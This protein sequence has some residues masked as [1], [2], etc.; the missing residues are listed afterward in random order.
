MTAKTQ[1]SHMIPSLVAA[2]M[3]ILA[4]AP[5]PYGYYQLLRLVTCG[6]AVYVAFVA[7]SWQKIWAV[8]IF[9]FVTLL[10]NPLIPIHLARE[11]WQP[12]DVT[13]AILFVIM[14]FVLKK[15]EEEKQ[16]EN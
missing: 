7:Y 15:P 14:A 5:W 8:W 16:E 6:I 9:G 12:I 10:F 1:R 3:L 13:C 2:V 4:L 11:I